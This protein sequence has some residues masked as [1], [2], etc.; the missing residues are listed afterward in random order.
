[1]GLPVF[2][3]GYPRDAEVYTFFLQGYALK[4]PIC[5][6]SD[7]MGSLGVMVHH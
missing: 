4:E 6:D 3:R 7:E 2:L 5:R 1:M